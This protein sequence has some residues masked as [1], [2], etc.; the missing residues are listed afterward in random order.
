MAKVHGVAGEWARVRGSVMGLWPLM[1]GIAAA[2]FSLATAIFASVG[3]GLVMLVLS[4]VGVGLTLLR[5]FRHV[6]RYFK[7]ARGE[8][9]VAGILA[10]LPDTYHVFNDFA[11]RS[12]H[13]DHVVVGPTGVFAV[14]TKFWKGPVTVDDGHVLVNGRLPSRSPLAQV[15]REAEAVRLTLAERGWIGQVTPVVAFAADNF[16]AHIAEVGTVVLINAG[17]IAASFGVSRTLVASAE[18][19]RLV[20]LMEME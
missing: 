2:G 3:C 7:G 11:C 17:D 6:E 18:I 20:R 9:K 19:E 10:R 14:E 13:V 12:L 4:G 16:S 15:M 5:G 8:E 1:I